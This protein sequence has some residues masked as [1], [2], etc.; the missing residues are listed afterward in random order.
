MNWLLSVLYGLWVIWTGL[1]RSIEAGAYKPN[2]LWFCL[3]MG[4]VGIAAGFFFRLQRHRLAMALGLSSSGIVLLYYFF[5][6][7]NQP[8]NDATIRVGL[9]IVASIGYIAMILMP[10]AAQTK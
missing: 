2:S 10:R 6:F 3:T 5:S 1:S 4:I 9:M 7:V 8:E